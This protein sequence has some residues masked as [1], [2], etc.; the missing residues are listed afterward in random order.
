MTEKRSSGVLVLIFVAALGLRLGLMSYQEC[1]ETDG[2]AYAQMASEWVEESSMTNQMFPPLYPALIGIASKVVAD[3]ELAARL[4]SGLAGSLLIFPLFWLAQRIYGV[5]VAL[6]TAS[7]VA[8]YPPLVEASTQALTESTFTLVLTLF[9]LAALLTFKGRKWVWFLAAGALL[10]VDYLVRP[11]AI[12][13]LPLVAA[14]YLGSVFWEAGSDKMAAAVNT[15][16]FLVAAMVFILPYVVHVGGLTGKTT[17]TLIISQAVGQTH[18]TRAV[19]EIGAADDGAT[20]APLLR[21][22]LADPLTFLKRWIMNLHLV[23]KYVL[24]QLFPPI[25]IALVVLGLSRFGGKREEFF[26]LFSW[27]PYVT[28]LFFYVDARFFVPLLPVALIFAGQGMEL[29]QDA[30]SRKVSFVGAGVVG[31]LVLA[32]V[33]TS[34][35]PFTLRPLYRPDPQVSYRDAG[36]WLRAHAG[37]RLKIMDRKPQ[38]AFYAGGEHI[39][40]PVGSWEEVLRFGKRESAT[41]LVID[42]QYVPETRPELQFL[43]SPAFAPGGLSLAKEFRSGDSVRVLVYELQ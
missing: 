10:G 6:V 34:L 7:L 36:L 35:L 16:C 3:Y 39:R 25:V 9:F 5:A 23:H 26:L 40:T 12:A 28:L 32:V 30:L 29:I 15:G 17:V 2:V 42:D 24:P 14:V 27:L 8:F 18:F 13:Y 43:L 38:V 1:I 19:D 41:H 4:V 31:A 21:A 37:P 20:S 33:V 11:E 22:M